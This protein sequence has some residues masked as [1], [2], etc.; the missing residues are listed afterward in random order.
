M[1]TD[2]DGRRLASVRLVC[3]CSPKAV[4]AKIRGVSERADREVE[5]SLAL[6]G[7]FSGGE[8]S[9]GFDNFRDEVETSG[10]EPRD[11]FREHPGELFSMATFRVRCRRMAC[12][13]VIKGHTSDLVD[14]V[15]WALVRDLRQ[16]QL[17]SKALAEARHA[18]GNA[19]D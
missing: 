7:D 15:A 11:W 19:G 17:T 2:V 8:W 14:L 1:T 12:R 16:V 6:D 3:G 5:Y 10:L 9:R 13:R 18:A 4:L